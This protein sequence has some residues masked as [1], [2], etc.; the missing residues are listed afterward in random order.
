[1]LKINFNTGYYLRFTLTVCKVTCSNAAEGND[2]LRIYARIT[3][4]KINTLY[5][6]NVNF[7]MLEL[8][9]IDLALGTE[10]LTVK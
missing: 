6:R 8:W 10:R 3:L 9:H 5:I 2:R 1:M 7:R 4:K